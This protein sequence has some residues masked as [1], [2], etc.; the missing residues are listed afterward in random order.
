[1]ELILLV[2]LVLS[3]G[4]NFYALILMRRYNSKLRYLEYDVEHFVED[5]NKRI[6]SQNS[7]IKEAREELKSSATKSADPTSPSEKAVKTIAS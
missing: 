7:L 5:T 4:Y 2:I 6:D 1:M 3:L